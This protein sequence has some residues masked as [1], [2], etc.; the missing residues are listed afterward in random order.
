MELLADSWSQEEE[1]KKGSLEHVK[2]EGLS[3]YPMFSVRIPRGLGSRTSGADGP[4]VD[5]SLLRQKSTVSLLF[6]LWPCHVPGEILVPWPGI[7]LVLL[8]LGTRSLNHWTVR[9]V[10]QI[11]SQRH[12]LFTLSGEDDK[13]YYKTAHIHTQCIIF[14]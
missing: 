5:G 14:N 4:E 2:E 11:H 1:K 12:S 7:E 3:K 13:Q 6:F 10:L 8:A 9:E